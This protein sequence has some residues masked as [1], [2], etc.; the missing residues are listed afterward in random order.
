MGSVK[1]GLVSDVFLK[2][3]ENISGFKPIFKKINLPLGKY[4]S[5]S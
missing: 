1:P 5:L 2:Q 3:E 4:G